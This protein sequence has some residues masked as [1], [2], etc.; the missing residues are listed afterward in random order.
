MRT[1]INKWAFLI[2]G[3][4]L[5]TLL[6]LLVWVPVHSQSSTTKK[7][8]KVINDDFI[9]ESGKTVLIDD[10]AFKGSTINT[11]EKYF[12][13]REEQDEGLAAATKNYTGC[14]PQLEIF[15]NTGT[16]MGRKIVCEDKPSKTYI[17]A[18]SHFDSLNK[19]NVISGESR[20]IVEE[21]VKGICPYAYHLYPDIECPGFD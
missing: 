13:D 2:P 7:D 6:V 12:D 16:E 11:R 18:Y 19:V 8:Y 9:I 21:F 4:L 5:G 3:F 1:L 20:S 17:I 14:G 10:Y 15:N